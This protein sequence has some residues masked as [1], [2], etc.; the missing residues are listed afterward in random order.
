L[1]GHL[2]KEWTEART[3]VVR[4]AAVELAIFLVAGFGLG[5]RGEEVV[6]I[7]IAGFMTFFEAGRDHASPH[8]MIPLLGRFK[9]EIGERWHLLPIAWKSRSGIKVGS[10]ASCL[11][12][13]LLERNRRHGFVF[14]DK[15]GKQTKASTLE[16]CFYEQLK[17]VRVRYPDLFA[18]N[19]NIEDDYGIAKLCW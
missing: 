8:V 12:T 13:L 6:K 7:D 14:A 3:A 18:P 19:V 15:K 5:L 10:W 11:L 16:P 4:Q 1:Q 17:W 2:K 9:D